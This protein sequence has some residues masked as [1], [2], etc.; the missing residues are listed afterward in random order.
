[1]KLYTDILNK[2]TTEVINDHEVQT[3]YWHCK[4][5]LIKDVDK[6]RNKYMCVGNYCKE[7]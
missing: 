2:N 1:M 3:Y 4:Y 5:K 7:F 6:D